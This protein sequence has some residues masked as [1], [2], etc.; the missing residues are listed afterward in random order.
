MPAISGETERDATRLVSFWQIAGTTDTLP[1]DPLAR[2][3]VQENFGQLWIQLGA[4]IAIL[5]PAPIQWDDGR[6]R[7]GGLLIAT[8]QRR[9]L[10][11]GQP[12][13][14]HD[15][16]LTLS[17]GDRSLRLKYHYRQPIRHSPW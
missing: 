13:L 16:H 2:Q 14:R 8:D 1:L 7:T 10:I 6:C 17:I 11:V 4:S 15:A 5:T 9:Q 12:D 3:S